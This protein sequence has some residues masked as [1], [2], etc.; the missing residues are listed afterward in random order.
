MAAPASV[1]AALAYRSQPRFLRPFSLHR[2]VMDLGYLPLFFLGQSPCNLSSQNIAPPAPGLPTPRSPTDLGH[3]PLSWEH[4]Y[5]ATEHST[6][7]MKPI[8]RFGVD[9]SRIRFLSPSESTDELFYAE[10]VRTV[11]KDN[12]FSFQSV[13]YETPVDLRGRKVELRYE[14][15]RQGTVVIYDKGRRLGCGKASGCRCQWPS[16][17]P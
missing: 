2:G 9:L 7:G 16:T 14:R 6:L 8:D 15:H 1:S 13:R 4:E 3:S 5:N 12:T 17:S 11:K 10:A